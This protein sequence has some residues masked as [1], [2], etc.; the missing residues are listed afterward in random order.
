MGVVEFFDV[1][2]IRFNV[3]ESEIV[4]ERHFSSLWE[5]N[6]YA[7]EYG[8]GYKALIEPMYFNKASISA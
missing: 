4:D 3:W 1:I 2:I 5:A 7:S 8:E 6:Q